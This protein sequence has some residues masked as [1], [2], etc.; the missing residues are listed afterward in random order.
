MPED[1][2]RMTDSNNSVSKFTSGLTLVG[3][4]A[5]ASTIL[6][7]QPML[8]SLRISPLIIGILLGVLVGNTIRKKLP[9]SVD[10]GI[11]FSA[12]KI[13]RLAIILYGFRITFDQIVSVGMA[14]VL[15]DI[16]MVASTLLIGAFVGIRILKMDR[17]TAIM[18]SAGAAICGAAAVIATE[19]VVK[20]E[21]HK[22]AVAVATVVCFGTLSMFLYPLVYRLGVIPM[23]LDVFGVYIGASVHEVAHVVGA[24]DAVSSVTSD[25]AVIVKMTRVMLLAPALITIGWLL[26]R[27]TKHAS[28]TKPPVMIPWFAVGFILVAAFNSFALLPSTWVNHINTVDTFL[29]TMAMTALG[30]NTVVER[31]KG[32]GLA[33]L[34]LAATLFVWLVLGGYALTQLFVGS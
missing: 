7:Q 4:I 17:E 2:I 23:S 29:L 31:F 34:Y 14:G 15:L 6:A 32:I 25:I 27:S 3:T 20:A 5:L 18:T 30:L 19:P 22:T 1:H 11:G 8:K 26:A 9:T 13:L 24:G 21:P 33:P 16:V 12:S 10:A 28:G